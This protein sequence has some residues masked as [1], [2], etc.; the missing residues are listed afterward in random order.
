MISRAADPTTNESTG[1]TSV[2]HP[3]LIA[4]WGIWTISALFYLMGFY[5]RV[6][7]SVMTDELMRAFGIGAASLGTLS[8]FYYYFYVAMQIPTGV[9]IDMLGVRKLLIGGAAIATLGA[10]TFGSTASFAMACIGRAIIGGS[11][12]VGWVVLLK[13][14]THWFPARKFAMLSG[15]GLLFGNLGALT[16]QVPLRVSI[17]HFGWRPVVI[18]SALAIALVGIGAIFLVRDDPSER[19]YRS[20]AP[21]GVQLTRLG[22]SDLL[23]GFRRIF[24]YR[25]TWL[26]FISQGGVVGSILTFTGLWGTPYLRM[27]YGLQGHASR[28]GLLSD[29]CLLGDFKSDLGGLSD[30]VGRRKPIYVG[31]CLLATAGWAG[32]FFLPHLP[33]GGFVVI[34][35]IT[36]MASGAVVIG[37]AFGKESVPAQFLGTISGTVNIGNMI[38]PMLLQPAIGRVLDRAWSGQISHGVHVYSAPAYQQG[39]LLMIAWLILSTILLSFTRETFCHQAV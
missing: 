8:A 12:A 14:T 4:A 34:G 6:S 24:G 5:Q 17:Q 9:L 29:D 10:L 11:T 32:L 38:G 36:A 19:G 39:F 2:L 23:V 18:A 27:R 16:A 3:P 1:T 37:F 15:L 7:P 33:L 35:A 21:A 26:I 13:L 25:N 28:S 20:H 31:G 30:R 22:L